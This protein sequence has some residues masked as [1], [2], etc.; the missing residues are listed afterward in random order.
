MTAKASPVN[1]TIGTWPTAW[2][3]MGGVCGPAGLRR[4]MLPHYRPKDLRDVLAWE[5]PGAATDDDAFADVAALCRD[6]FNRKAPDFAPVACDL[7]TVGPFARRIL[8]ACRQIA[9][10]ERL[11]YAA[12]AAAAG[13]PGK[14]RPAA[15]ALGKNPIP[16]IIPC[17]RVVAAGGKLGGFS[18][19]GGVDQK[20][21]MLELERP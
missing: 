1:E 12:L 18:A 13:E 19:P 8:A 5:H 17:H 16:L 7:S 10:G 3:L 9:H 15:Q 4:I 6:Y 2:G 14:A 20:A 21:R 11:T